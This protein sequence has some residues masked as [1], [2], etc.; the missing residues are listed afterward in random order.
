MELPESSGG[1]ELRIP[2]SGS[3]AELQTAAD[4]ELA[5]GTLESSGQTP[6]RST[7]SMPGLS[8]QGGAPNGSVANAREPGSG[9]AS[10][11]TGGSGAAATFSIRRKSYLGS[12]AK[13]NEMYLGHR[14]EL[15][16]I[17]LVELEKDYPKDARIL[18]MKG[19][20]YEKL[21]KTDLAKASWQ[22]SLELSPGDENVT[23]AL[24]QLDERKE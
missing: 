7:G 21:G 8:P 19:S 15:A 5:R 12:L 20:L 10:G 18:A 11:V 22:K 23:E 17:E 1:Y 13:V 6:D 4:E 9:T 16:L 24:K 3:P 14:F 2:L